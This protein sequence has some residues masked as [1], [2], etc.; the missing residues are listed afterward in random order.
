MVGIS[1]CL[2]AQG[3]PGYSFHARAEK[4]TAAWA[5]TTRG[6]GDRNETKSLHL[7]HNFFDIPLAAGS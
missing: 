1:N 4:R 7:E 6:S 3:S 2:H 5:I